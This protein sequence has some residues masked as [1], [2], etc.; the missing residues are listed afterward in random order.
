MNIKKI[1]TVGIMVVAASV[2]A[3]GSLTSI[4]ARQRYPWNGMVDVDC[5]LTGVAGTIYN[6]TVAAFDKDGGT[7]LVVKTVSLDGSSNV[8]NPV[9]VQPGTY[10]LV[11]NADE[12]VPK[13]F[14]SSRVSISVTVSELAKEFMVVDL[15]SG[16]VSYLATAPSEGWNTT[17]Y[18][19]TKMVFRR[20]A[21]GT[22][23]QCDKGAHG[24]KVT[25]SKPF[26]ISIFPITDGQYGAL[27]GGD[28]TGTGYASF[29]SSAYFG[30]GGSYY[31]TKMRGNDNWPQGGHAVTSGSPIGV[32]RSITGMNNFDLP[33]AGLLGLALNRVSLEGGGLACLDWFLYEL[34]EADVTDPMG[35]A[36]DTL[37]PNYNGSGFR[38]YL[39]SSGNIGGYF[40][41]SSESTGVRICYYDAE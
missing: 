37:G 16:D 28:M 15:Q 40:F 24:R 23:R 30:G 38:V 3:S 33:T 12:D 22:F 4:S 27:T 26:Y 34:G 10:R 8:G 19:T 21:A 17:I 36:S 5:T 11:W 14:R 29:A 6:L 7:N 35:P 18:K 41:G 20:I 39:N 13:G 25:I 31:A 1:L 2:M 9:Q 32:L